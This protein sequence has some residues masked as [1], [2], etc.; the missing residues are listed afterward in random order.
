VGAINHKFSRE[1]RE[2]VA[3]GV[4]TIDKNVIHDLGW[5]EGEVNVKRENAIFEFHSTCV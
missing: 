1:K 2:R 5:K 3:D 4:A